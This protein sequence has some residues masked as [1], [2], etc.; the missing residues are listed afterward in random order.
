MD[1]SIIRDGF[2]LILLALLGGVL[3]P[4][5]INPRLGVGAHTLGVLGGLVLIAIGATRPVSALD[6][7]LW[8]A[9]KIFWLVAAYANWANTML[10]GLTGSSYLTPI[11]GAGTTGAP[12]AEAVVF[13]IYIVVGVTSVLG[14]VLAVYGLV[15][16]CGNAP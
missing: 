6:K 15:R 3:A 11:A 8:R 2:L 13:A 14:T 1:R 10:A 4:F 7:K 12:F 5:M 9:M 16:S